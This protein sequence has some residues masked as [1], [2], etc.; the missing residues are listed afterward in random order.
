MS[1]IEIT[2]QDCQTPFT[3][4]E[5][6]QAFY[7]EKGFVRPKRCRHCRQTRKNAGGQTD[8]RQSSGE[9]SGA[10]RTGGGRRDGGYAAPRREFHDAICVE[11]GTETQVPFKPSGDRPVR[12][13]DCYSR[14]KPRR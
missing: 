13:R 11:C 5:Q 7:E 8:G 4:S 6:E 9:R 1:D 2:C 10:D 12:C 14:T 3:F